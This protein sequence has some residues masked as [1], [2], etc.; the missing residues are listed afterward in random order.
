[1][2]TFVVYHMIHVRTPYQYHPKLV[3]TDVPDEALTADAPDEI[4][5]LVTRAGYE[6]SEFNIT[7]ANHAVHLMDVQSSPSDLVMRVRK[8]EGERITFADLRARAGASI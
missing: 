4:Q 5:E 6:F 8:G 1:M 7:W 2:S 3:I